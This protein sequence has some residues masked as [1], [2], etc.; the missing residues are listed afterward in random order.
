M[1]ISRPVSVVAVAGVLLFRLIVSVAPL[2]TSQ[3]KDVAVLKFATGQGRKPPD[4]SRPHQ[5]TLRVGRSR[6][7]T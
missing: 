3:S 1:M 6:Q 2:V 5:V 7:G 4:A